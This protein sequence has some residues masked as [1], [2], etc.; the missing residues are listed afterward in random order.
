LRQ[1]LAALGIVGM[2]VQQG[3]FREERPVE[4]IIE[5]EREPSA[6]ADKTEV[7][8]IFNAGNFD[9]LNEERA[10]GGA[11]DGHSLTQLRV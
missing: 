10:C 7:K 8:N 11:H 5:A 4:A 9:A 6:V 2:T 1:A 3:V